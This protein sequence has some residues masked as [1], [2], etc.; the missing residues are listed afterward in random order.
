MAGA[1]DRHDRRRARPTGSSSTRVRLRR[2]GRGGA[3]PRRARHHATSTVAVPAGRGRAA[4]TATTSSTTARS[5]PSSAASD[6]PRRGSCEAL[7]RDG[8]GMV[9]DIV[10]NHMAIAGAP[11]TAG[12][13]TCSRTD[14][15]AATRLL[16][17][18]LGPAGVGCATRVLLPV[19]GDHYGRVL[20]AGE[21]RVVRD[22]G[23]F[24]VRYH[25]HW[26]RSPRGRSTP[27]W[28]RAAGLTARR[29]GL[30]RRRVRAACRSSTPT[31][32]GRA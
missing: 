11:R 19:L 15:R 26:F 32:R 30:P 29:A 12:G 21:L 25:D 27:C 23:S 9:L 4:P 18:R 16:R 13:G 24:T 3:V 8:L 28:R 14:R 6:G 31:D 5:T 7:R 10:P 2:R 22:G 20:E 17:R 1:G